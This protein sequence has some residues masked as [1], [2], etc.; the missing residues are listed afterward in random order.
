MNAAR[1]ALEQHRFYPAAARPLGLSGK[2]VFAMMMDETGRVRG[3]RLMK[4]SGAEI[5]DR[6]AAEMIRRASPFPRPPADLAGR[7]I[8]VEIPMY[9]D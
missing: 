2:S 1:A 7:E 5:L 8:V 6:A 9:P 4:S 3:L